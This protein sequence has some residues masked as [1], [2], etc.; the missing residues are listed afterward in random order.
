MSK[1]LNDGMRSGGEAN[2]IDGLPAICD[3][4]TNYPTYGN[5]T[6]ATDTW[7]NAYLDGTGGA[8]SNTMFQTTYGEA[9]QNNQQPDMIMTTQAVYNSIWGKMTPQQRY[10]QLDS[11]ADVRALGFD[12]MEFNRAIVLTDDDLTAGLAFFLNTSFM[13]FVVHSDRNMSWQDFMTHLDEDART[14]R[15]Y[16]MGNLICTAPRYFAQIQNIT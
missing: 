9:S 5:I 1:I 14:G 2:Q 16:W 10:Q 11:N 15:F 6:R 4:G 13:E 8:Y 12:G 3:D 7:A